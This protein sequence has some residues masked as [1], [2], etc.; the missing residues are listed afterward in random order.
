MPCRRFFTTTAARCSLV[1]PELC[2]RRCARSAKYE[3]VEASPEAS[4]QGSKNE[5]RMMPRGIFSTP[6][7]SAVSICPDSMALCGERERG[8]AARASRL[9][10]DDRHPR[11]AEPAE[12]LVP[13]RDAPV[14]GR[15]E[16][17]LEPAAPDACFVEGVASPR[18]PRDPWW[19]RLRT[20]PNGWIPTPDQDLL[21]GATTDSRRTPALFEGRDVMEPRVRTRR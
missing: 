11:H 10:V 2:I 20:C 13:G 3:G 18:R 6:N 17:G 19:S 8:S 1:T 9:H 21:H 16:G 14:R 12:H 4:C 7:T 5:E 15:T